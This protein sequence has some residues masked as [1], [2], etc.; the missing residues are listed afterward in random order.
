MRFSARTTFALLS[1]S[2]ASMSL[3][4]RAAADPTPAAIQYET[5]PSD[6]PSTQ[7]LATRDGKAYVATFGKS[8]PWAGIISISFYT[9]QDA[10]RV[11]LPIS[12]TKQV[13]ASDY[14]SDPI[15]ILNPAAEKL[16]DA[17]I[18]F[19]QTDDAGPCIDY[20]HL[21]DD[22]STDPDVKKAYADLNPAQAPVSPVKVVGESAA[23]TCKHPYKSAAVAGDSAQLVYPRSAQIAG[24]TGRVL[25]KIKLTPTASVA[26]ASIFRS[27]GNS[28][29]DASALS[30]ATKTLY[31]P[32][33]FRCQPVVSYY[34]FA[35]N[36]E[37]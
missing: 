4:G 29:L 36:F 8:T 32:E 7:V 25:V 24:A 3:P 13:G 37:P 23:L 10:Y 33:I 22:L 16:D 14:R 31:S 19:G 20:F 15:T 35:A 6:C 1:L 27:S 21:P 17:E 30:T 5:V 34:L 11:Q 28:Y 12:A 18:D 2:V 9:A 26:E